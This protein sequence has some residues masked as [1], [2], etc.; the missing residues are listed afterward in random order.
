MMVEC[1]HQFLVR[2][3]TVMAPPSLNLIL[4]LDYAFMICTANLYLVHSIL[5]CINTIVVLLI[6]IFF[7]IVYYVLTI[8]ESRSVVKL[9]WSPHRYG[10]LASLCK[11]S[12]VVKL[13]NVQHV[14]KYWRI[15]VFINF[16]IL[17]VAVLKHESFWWELRKKTHKCYV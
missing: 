15:W 13:Y 6:N 11:D 3:P 16:N 10:V 1:K 7:L 2:I 9:S 17:F 5:K 14:C 12:S 8:T 4:D